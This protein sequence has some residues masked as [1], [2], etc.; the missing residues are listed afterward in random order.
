[1]EKEMRLALA[2]FRLGVS[3]DKGRRMLFTGELTG[4]QEN[5]KWLVDTESVER[6]QRQGEPQLVATG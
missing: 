6:L 5:G 2:C 1:M 3:Y 4:R